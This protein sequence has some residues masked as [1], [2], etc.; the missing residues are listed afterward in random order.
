MYVPSFCYVCMNQVHC[1]GFYEEFYDLEDSAAAVCVHEPPREWVLQ[2]MNELWELDNTKS[3][4][5]AVYWL[6]WYKS[7]NS[8]DAVEQAGALPR[9]LWS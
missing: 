8:D 6:Y 9:R 7:T 1:G 2:L 4:R 5:Y 3:Q